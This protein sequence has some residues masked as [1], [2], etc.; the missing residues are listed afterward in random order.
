MWLMKHISYTR[1][2]LTPVDH[3]MPGQVLFLTGENIFV[4]QNNESMGLI[5]VSSLLSMP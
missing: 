4:V 2:Q 1:A 3:L 5:A